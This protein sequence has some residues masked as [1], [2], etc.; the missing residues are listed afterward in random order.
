MNDFEIYDKMKILHQKEVPFLRFGQ[1][2][3][4]FEHWHFNRY[5]NDT[6]YL[7]DKE[8]YHRLKE[9]ILGVKKRRI[10]KDANVS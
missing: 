6:F 4:N 3:M 10:I 5:G 8:Y 7:N 1:L 9:Y 2:I